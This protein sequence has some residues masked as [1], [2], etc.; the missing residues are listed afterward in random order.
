MAEIL[1]VTVCCSGTAALRAKM[2]FF[3][4]KLSN[5]YLCSK[6]L[7]VRFNY[8]EEIIK[9]LGFVSGMTLIT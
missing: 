3:L 1:S 6:M 5:G 9:E 8:P 4:N 2:A 7:A